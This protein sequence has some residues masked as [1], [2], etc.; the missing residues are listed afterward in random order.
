MTTVPFL[1]LRPTH[2]PIRRELETAF[3]E[4]LAR[5]TFVLGPEV[6]RFEAEFAR[7][8]NAGHCVGVGNGLDALRIILSSC[9]IGCG[10]EVIVPAHTFFATW[11]AVSQVGAT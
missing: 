11:L 4:T 10:D 1:D 7:L 9:G 6:E 2:E 3:A 8:C 5:S